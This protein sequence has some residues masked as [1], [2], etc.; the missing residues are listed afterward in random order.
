MRVAA[1][2]R[3]DLLHE[4]GGDELEGVGGHQEPRLDFRIETRVHPR[5]LEL[6]FEI[7]DGA[8]AAHDDAG[9]DRLG[10]THQQG[11]ERAHL[12]PVAAAVVEMGHLAAHDL[13]PLVGREQGALAVIAR[14]PD[15]QP[16]DDVQ[17]AADDVG[18]P[19]S[20][21]I[22][23]AGVDADAPTHLSSLL[24]SSVPPASSAPPWGASVTPGPPFS[25][26]S[27]LPFSSSL[28]GSRA[29]ETTRSPSPTLNTTT[30]A[31]PRRAMRMSCTGTRITMPPSVTSISWSLWPIGKTATTA[32]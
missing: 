9:L 10:E 5:H 3:A 6:V 28:S 17:R 30:P 23:G 27:P 26:A 31:L 4:T 14:N 13:D 2:H 29:T 16:I 22:E 18:M 1:P 12:N 20:D 32:S 24:S 21:R 7:G 15:H 19:V 25:S 8:Q 11:V